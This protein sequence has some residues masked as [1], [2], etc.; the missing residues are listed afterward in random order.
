MPTTGP[1]T[2][3]EAVTL[4]ARRDGADVTV[5]YRVPAVRKAV[6][7]LYDVAGRRIGPSYPAEV[8]PGPHEI[9]I[10][11]SLPVGV[12]LV[13]LETDRGVR[14]VRLPLF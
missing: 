4:R 7:H 14:S 5:T 11:G 10:S 1:V 2:D 12:Y 3:R 13:T 8:T 9:T 6:I